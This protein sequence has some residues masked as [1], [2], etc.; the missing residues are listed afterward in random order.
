MD[1]LRGNGHSDFGRG[2]AANIYADGRSNA[3]QLSLAI[4]FG[5]ECF[6]RQPGLVFATH[7]AYLMHASFEQK[8]LAVSVMDVAARHNHGIIL[9]GGG[10]HLA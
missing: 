2:F 3:G 7:D 4:A 10:A 9:A 5:Q 6:A 1:E 8:A